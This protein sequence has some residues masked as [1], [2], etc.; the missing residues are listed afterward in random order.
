MK[1]RFSKLDFRFVNKTSRPKHLDFNT[2]AFL[3]NR[4]SVLVNE[5]FVLVNRIFGFSKLGFR[6][7]FVPGPPRVRGPMVP[8]SVPPVALRGPIGPPCDMR[9]SQGRNF[10]SLGDPGAH[11]SVILPDRTHHRNSVKLWRDRY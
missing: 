5:I 6:F 10:Q 3:V 1:V 2:S 7:F 8:Q 4:I 9:A 11:P